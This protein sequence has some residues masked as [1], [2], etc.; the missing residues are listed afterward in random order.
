MS[1]FGLAEVAMARTG[2]ARVLVVVLAV[3]LQ[4][5]SAYYLPGVAATNYKVRVRL[6]GPARCA[7]CCVLDAQTALRV[8]SSDAVQEHD[9][10]ELEVNALSSPNSVVPFDY[11]HKMLNFCGPE[12]PKPS[13]GSLGAILFGDRKY[14]SLI[15]L[16]ML[17][18]TTCNV[19]CTR[20]NTA[21]QT[22]FLIARIQERYLINW[23]T[24]GSGWV[25]GRLRMRRDVRLGRGREGAHAD[26]HVHAPMHAP[27]HARTRPCACAHV[28]VFFWKVR[29]MNAH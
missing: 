29:R 28:H 4:A 17:S 24:S 7:L 2:A 22:N 23:Y 1:V 26:M 13:G 20:K 6:R 21:Q 12:N 14:D 16:Y 15:K 8:G 3:A 25:C 10:V 11:Y 27:M 9:E 18:N 19:L 5:A